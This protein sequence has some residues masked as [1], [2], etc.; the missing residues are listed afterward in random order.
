MFDV[1]EE[2]FWNEVWSDDCCVLV[3]VRPY[4]RRLV[5][6]VDSVQ[7]DIEVEGAFVCSALMEQTG[8]GLAVRELCPGG[9]TV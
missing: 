1:F 3:I 5:G 9:V 4:M 8:G 7:E 2:V 6:I